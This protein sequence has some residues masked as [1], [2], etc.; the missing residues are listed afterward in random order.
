[1]TLATPLSSHCVL[2]TSDIDVARAS[3]SASLAPHRLLP[4][5]RTDGFRARHNIVDL[6]AVT[7]HYLDYGCEVEVVVEAMDAQLVQIPLAGRTT[8]D[9]GAGTVVARPGF[10]AITPV[11]RSLRMGYSS[12]NPRVVVEIDAALLQQRLDV[13]RAGGVD[14]P[15]HAGTTLDLTRGAGR[16]WR[17]IVDLLLADCERARGLTASP[18]A[19]SSLRLALVDGLVSGM[20]TDDDEPPASP[21]EAVIHRA[22]RLIEEHCAEQLGTPDIAAAVQLSV[23]ALQAGFRAHLGTTPMAYLRM[24]RLQRIHAMLSDG[25]ASSVTEAALRWGM[26]HLGRLAVDY[27][28]AYAESP[29][30]TLRRSG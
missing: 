3:I 14:V 8:L 23:R 1:M 29:S 5:R 6:G 15:A 19:A 9:A 26:P 13:A 12:G 28:A 30:Q 27:R 24:V 21:Q 7:L 16:S 25:S 10:A 22:A 4:V 2:S 17:A 18:A 11:G 20:A